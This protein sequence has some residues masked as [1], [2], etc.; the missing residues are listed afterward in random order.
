[1]QLPNAQVIYQLL[2]S[3]YCNMAA[4]KVLSPLLR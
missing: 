3:A 1:M 2:S 4:Q